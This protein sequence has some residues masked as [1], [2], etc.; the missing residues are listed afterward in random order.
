VGAWILCGFFIYNL[1]D[2][3]LRAIFYIVYG[4]VLWLPAIAVI[5]K[6]G[7]TLKA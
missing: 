7:K 4:F 3:G 1:V 2:P 5:L 6:Y